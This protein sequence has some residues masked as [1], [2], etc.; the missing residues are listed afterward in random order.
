VDEAEKLLT[1]AYPDVEEAAPKAP[2]KGQ[3]MR[4]KKF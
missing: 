3:P 1:Q 4:K 2:L